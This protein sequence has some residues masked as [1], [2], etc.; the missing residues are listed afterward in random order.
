[1]K[2]EACLYGTQFRIQAPTT[3]TRAR[4]AFSPRAPRPAH[5]PA[6]GK[7]TPGFVNFSAEHLPNQESVL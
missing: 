7:L 3:R 6:P 2:K 4:S 1:M 5:D